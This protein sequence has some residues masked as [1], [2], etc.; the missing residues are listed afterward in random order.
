MRL[1][2]KK[3]TKVNTCLRCESK[4]DGASGI[5]QAHIPT[6]GSISICIYCG[7]IAIFGDD[8]QLCP[9]T[10]E[11]KLEIE[12]LPEIRKVKEAI[13]VTNKVMKKQLH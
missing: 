12:Q 6:P 9:M 11:E 2:E 8:M 13:E 3:K 1:N 7:N 4:L 5:N 10:Q